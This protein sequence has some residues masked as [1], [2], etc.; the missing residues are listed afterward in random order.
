MEHYRFH[1]SF[2]LKTREDMISYTVE[3]S[4]KQFN[5]PKMSSIDVTFNST[6][7]LIHALYIPEP[8]IP[9]V[10]QVNSHNDA[11]RNL[12]EIFSKASPSTIPLRVPVR[13]LVQ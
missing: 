5:I 6:Q 10:K 3:F 4:P 2:I 12:S 1:K 7:G 9:L 11:L 8:A 13:K